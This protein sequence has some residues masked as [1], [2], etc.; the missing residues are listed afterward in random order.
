MRVWAPVTPQLEDEVRP[1]VGVGVPSGVP[2]CRLFFRGSDSRELQFCGSLGRC[3]CFLNRFCSGR[4]ERPMIGSPPDDPLPDKTWGCMLRK[5]MPSRQCWD[6]Q[7][8]TV[9]CGIQ[10]MELLRL[11]GSNP[12]PNLSRK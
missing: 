11:S 2:V 7:A 4:Q 8:E 6:T 5:T 3:C 10:H 1:V 12:I 9:F